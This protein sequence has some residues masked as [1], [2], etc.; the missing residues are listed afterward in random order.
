MNAI[1]WTTQQV[2]KPKRKWEPKREYGIPGR[3][4]PQIVAFVGRNPEGVCAQQIADEIG[5]E[6]G[7]VRRYIR[8]ASKAGLLR[9]EKGTH[10]K[11]AA[12]LVFPGG[13]GPV[14]S[15]RDGIVINGRVSVAA[16]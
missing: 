13:S 6:P 7:Q 15:V 5:V 3:Q 16:R 12:L 2:L 8:Y 14:T 4:M 10:N 9:T 11:H 1:E